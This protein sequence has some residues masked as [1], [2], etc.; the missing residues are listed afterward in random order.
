[1]RRLRLE[2]SL[3]VFDLETTGTDTSR[4]RVVEIGLVR[5]EPD[6]RRTEWSRRVNPGI[7]IPAGATAVHGITDEDVRD[8]PALESVADEVLALLDGADVAGFNSL[9]FDWPLLT[10]EFERIGRP[11]ARG[12]VRHVDAMR[13]FH[14][15]EPRSLAAAMRFY[16]AR[17]HEEAH[18]ALA[19]ALATL[20]VIEAQVSRYEDLPDDVTGLHAVCSQ[21]RENWIDPEGK[22]AWN[23]AGDAVFTF[24][25]H[26][27]RSLRE[28]AAQDPSYLRFLQRSDLERPFSEAVRRIAQ[29]AAA[30]RFPERPAP[31]PAQG[32]LF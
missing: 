26:R 21:G 32:Q 29:D 15:R 14:L 2:R 22:L 13:I 9:G 6:G 3:V 20:A 16:C 31:G 4:D 7:P 1:M 5:V 8:A 11:L 27:G 23:D 30:G 24:G 19:D 12:E 25:K 10:A 17:D 28:V 18:S